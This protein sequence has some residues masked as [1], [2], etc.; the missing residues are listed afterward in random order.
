MH[1][2]NF[3][4]CFTSKSERRILFILTSKLRYKIGSLEYTNGDQSEAFSSMGEKSFKSKFLK[5]TFEHFHCH[6]HNRL[7]ATESIGS[8]LNHLP[9]GPRAQDPT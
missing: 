6:L 8:P 4:T 5:L 7:R 3:Q 1:M 2:L 9:K